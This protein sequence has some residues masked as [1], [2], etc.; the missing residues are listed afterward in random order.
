M[1]EGHHQQNIARLFQTSMGV[2]YPVVVDVVMAEAGA[3]CVC[4][5]VRVCFPWH[6]AGW[7]VGPWPGGGRARSCLASRHAGS[8]GRQGEGMVWGVGAHV[9]GIRLRC[10]LAVGLV[11]TSA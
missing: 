2:V 7:C 10:H 5:T 6:G 9:L 4:A 1:S 11:A 8:C 3:M